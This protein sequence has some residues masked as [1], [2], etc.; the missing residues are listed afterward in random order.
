[1]WTINT[2]VDFNRV[3]IW[4][5]SYFYIPADKSLKDID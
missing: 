5:G 3:T 1:M 4:E 2:S